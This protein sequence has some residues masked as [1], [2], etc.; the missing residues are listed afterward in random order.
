MLIR[1]QPGF[2]RIYANVAVENTELTI[3][4]VDCFC[5]NGMSELLE[6]VDI[7]EIR[8]LGGLFSKGNP[9]ESV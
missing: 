6:M 3:R 8:S 1:V 4:R 5:L 7:S 9:L 2:L